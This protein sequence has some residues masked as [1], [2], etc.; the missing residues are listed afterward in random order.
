MKKITG[1]AA[2]MALGLA[3]CGFCSGCAAGV[4]QNTE[5]PSVPAATVSADGGYK[6]ILNPGIHINGTTPATIES[7]AKVTKAG[8]EKFV[9]NGYIANYSTG[10]DLP[11]AE[12][13]R[14]NVT[15]AGWRYAVDGVPTV[16]TKMPDVS[17]LEGDLYLYAHW[18]VGSGNN[19]GPNPG[20][21]PTIPTT[22]M[23]VTF[24]NSVSVVIAFDA[25]SVPSDITVSN[26]SLH[27][28]AGS[29]DLLGSFPGKALDGGSTTV[30]V[31]SSAVSG[32]IISFKNGADTQQSNNFTEISFQ[33]GYT[34][35][36]AF[37]EWKGEWGHFDMTV[38]E[39][40]PA[41]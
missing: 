29:T 21:N 1:L 4:K 13:T 30:S 23:T 35:V 26:P 36:F 11:K 15:F 34:Y 40:A 27:M 10:E 6:V 3:F 20:P 31:A 9:E 24:N 22:K 16:V 39:I 14:S 2:T 17:K 32:M 38:T 8:S 33:N 7:G 18:T 19:P 37:K 41:A 28:W 12:T 25:S 5:A